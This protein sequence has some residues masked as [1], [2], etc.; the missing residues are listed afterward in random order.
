MS[1]NITMLKSFV[2]GEKIKAKDTNNN[3]T[4]LDKKIDQTKAELE[5]K[6]NNVSSSLTPF[7]LNNCSYVNG[8]RVFLTLDTSAD[9]QGTVTKVLHAHA[10]FTFTTGNR[11]TVEVTEDIYLD[12]TNLPADNTY[13]VY[14]DYNETSK[15]VTLVTLM[16]SIY[17]AEAQPD[18]MAINDIWIN[19]Q[20]PMSAYIKT[21]SSI[22]ETNKTLVGT[23]KGDTIDGT[24]LATDKNTDKTK[25][26]VNSG[27]V[28]TDGNPAYLVSYTQDVEIPATA[29][30]GT[31][32]TETHTYLKLLAGTVYTDGAS[33]HAVQ[34][35]VIL[36][37]TDL[38]VADTN[39]NVFVENVNGSDVLSVK[40]NAVEVCNIATVPKENADDNY[41]IIP[42]EPLKAY[43]VNSGGTKTG[44][45]VVHIGSYTG[46]G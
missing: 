33:T 34:S 43:W 38:N 11:M 20:E 46:G 23:Y 21:I 17:K 28:D 25:Y 41:L 2:E 9:E 13:N 24:G 8:K 3:N 10:P 12:V 42:Q 37:I 29:E 44:T 39:Y 31:A 7:S 40:S 45:N 18:N 1:S 19:T 35:D 5:T 15:I 36:D 32:T 4:Y 6:I 27:A 30:G 22:E 26:A 14:C 16:N